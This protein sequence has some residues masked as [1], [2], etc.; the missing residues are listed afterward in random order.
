MLSEA[1]GGFEARIASLMTRH[2]VTVADDATVEAAA[3]R[4]RHCRIRHLPVVDAAGALAGVIS[5][6]DVVPADKNALV[7]DIMKVPVL[8]TTEE[9]PAVRACER[10]LQ[11]HISCLPVVEGGRLLGIFTATDALRHAKSMLLMTSPPVRVEQLMTPP[12]ITSV[13]PDAPLGVAWTAMRE[14]RVRHLAVMTGEL[15]AGI[16]S[17]RDVL[18][19][20]RAWLDEAGHGAEHRA[21]LVADAMSTRV[22]TIEP[23][24]EAADAAH[25][26]LRRRVGALPVRRERRL[27][28]MLTVSDF[29]YW[30]LS[31]R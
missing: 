24:A 30:I 13:A 7:R 18:A 9:E 22:A 26:L 5:L 4:L 16:L 29:L 14:A 28:G 21:L 2:P 19:A 25:I 12:P 17:D 31:C 23:E 8:T 1:I 3:E 20:G 15:L 11:R 10:M 6:R 27:V